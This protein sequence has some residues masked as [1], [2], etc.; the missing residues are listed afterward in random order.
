MVKFSK[1]IQQLILTNTEFRDLFI[2]TVSS[3]NYLEE[4]FVYG[5]AREKCKIMASLM[6]DAYINY[7]VE[8]DPGVEF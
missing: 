2:D 7:L 3:Y 1:I 5:S 4:L 8:M 6:A